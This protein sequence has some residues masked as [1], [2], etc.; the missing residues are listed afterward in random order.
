MQVLRSRILASA[1]AAYR[2]GKGELGR[3]DG[4]AAAGGTAAVRAD[5]Y[6]TASCGEPTDSTLRTTDAMDAAAERSGAAHIA[7]ETA[8]AQ[9]LPSVLELI[10]VP[11][12]ARKARPPKLE[13]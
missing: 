5:R 12:G 10:H 2:C 8:R 4:A 11:V 3:A 6:P 7:A 1:A 13:A 9:R